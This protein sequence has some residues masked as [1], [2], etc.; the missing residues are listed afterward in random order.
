MFNIL[1]IIIALF[2][3]TIAYMN[4]KNRVAIAEMKVDIYEIKNFLIAIANPKKP[5]PKR[6]GRSTNIMRKK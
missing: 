6:K 1:I 4:Y 3:A 5:T 2:M